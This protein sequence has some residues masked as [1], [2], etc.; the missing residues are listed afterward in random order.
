[1]VFTPHYTGLLGLDGFINS[2]SSHL[3][4]GAAGVGKTALLLVIARN[5]C[6]QHS[7]CLYV[8]TEDPL[9]YDRVA[10]DPEAYSNVLF[11]DI[12]DFDEL[13]EFAVKALINMP[14]KVIFVDSV[15]SLYRL[16]SHRE[17]ALRRYNFFLALLFRKIVYDKMFL[18][19]SA[20]VRAS[21]ED[22]E[23]VVA[24]GFT[25]LRYWFDVA[26]QM[27]FEDEKRFIKIVKPS[28]QFKAYFKITNNGLIW[29]DH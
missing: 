21:L 8:N 22:E 10:R 29:V 17:S 1:M 5:I 12:K 23:E 15:N 3:F 13:I 16:E 19:A 18:F 11:L 14:I 2:F 9:F 20:Q 7:P 4:Y 26:Y 6:Q 27:G 24:S 25:I 28:V